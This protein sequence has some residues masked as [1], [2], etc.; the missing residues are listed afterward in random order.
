MALYHFAYSFHAF[1]VNGANSHTCYV[2]QFQCKTQG[3]T[4]LQKPAIKNAFI[5]NE[6][7][8]YH[9]N[10]KHFTMW[11]AQ[12]LYGTKKPNKNFKI[13]SV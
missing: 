3:E 6:K 4:R 8:L 5:A 11:H 12:T 7:C 13:V 2:H 9:K 10:A 1:T